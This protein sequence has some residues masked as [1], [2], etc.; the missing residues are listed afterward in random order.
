MSRFNFSI[1]SCVR[2]NWGGW[3]V[4]SMGFWEGGKGGGV[5]V[6][7]CACMH[8]NVCFYVC[9]RHL[10]SYKQGMMRRSQQTRS[11]TLRKCTKPEMDGDNLSIR[12]AILLSEASPQLLSCQ[13]V[14]WRMAA[15]KMNIKQPLSEWQGNDCGSTT[16]RPWTWALK[17]KNA[18]PVLIY[19]LL[20]DR[21]NL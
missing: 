16:E 3:K 18:L 15:G 14:K 20:T 13:S 19:L 4:D 17:P 9:V 6:L 10:V 5:C 2:P 11:R 1:C 21:Y 8:V 12:V 7:E